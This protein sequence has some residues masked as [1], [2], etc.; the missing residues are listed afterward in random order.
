MNVYTIYLS[1][2]PTPITINA[3]G[4]AHNGEWFSFYTRTETTNVTTEVA[5]VRIDS[6]TAISNAKE[7]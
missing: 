7:G 6:I 2:N 4:Y 1:T 3:D 5:R